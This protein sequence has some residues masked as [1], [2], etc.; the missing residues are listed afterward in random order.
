MHPE[1][2]EDW[3]DV[4]PIQTTKKIKGVT[5]ITSSLKNRTYDIR[6]D[7]P[8]PKINV[9]SWNISTIVPDTNIRGI[10]N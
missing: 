1:G 7:V 4:V 3:F 10:K 9:L 2:N 6:G 5:T 8:N